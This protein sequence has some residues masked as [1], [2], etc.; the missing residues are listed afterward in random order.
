MIMR[1]CAP[2]GW[3]L[4]VAGLLVVMAASITL[5]VMFPYVD[6]NAE[7]AGMNSEV[8]EAATVAIVGNDA[9]GAGG[10]AVVIDSSFWGGAIGGTGDNNDKDGM[11]TAVIH[12]DKEMSNEKEHHDSLFDSPSVV[13]DNKDASQCQSLL[14]QN[15]A[16]SNHLLDTTEYM[17]LLQSLSKSHS[18]EN[19]MSPWD[20]IAYTELPFQL[21][22]NF[23]HLACVCPANYI[24]D[25]CSEHKQGIYVGSDTE[26]DERLEKVCVQTT[27]AVAK[28]LENG[29]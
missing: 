10:G 25:C 8:D 3:L 11:D 24:G 4:A 15:D 20:T 29:H 27:E 21:K 12:E 16:D 23:N 14:Q 9:S 17:S 28:V 2:N 13:D 6:L 5:A 1:E 19:A 7:D 22:M 26:D 18:P